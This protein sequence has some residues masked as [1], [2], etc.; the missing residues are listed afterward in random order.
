MDLLRSGKGS[1]S[2]VAAELRRISDML[3]DES[4][5]KG[6]FAAERIQRVLDEELSLMER[7][8]TEY[9]GGPGALD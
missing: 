7:G 6:K 9:T 5:A 3:K 2:Q 8:M 1:N 4:T